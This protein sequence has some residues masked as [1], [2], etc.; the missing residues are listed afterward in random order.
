MFKCN[1]TI[2]GEGK[3]RMNFEAAVREIL[4]FVNWISEDTILPTHSFQ[5]ILLMSL[6]DSQS[7]LGNTGRRSS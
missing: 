6:E 3:Y 7:C 4:F 2:E 5:I 1:H